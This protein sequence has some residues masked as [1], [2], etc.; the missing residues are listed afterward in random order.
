MKN[1][2]IYFSL[3]LIPTWFFFRFT[4]TPLW[5]PRCLVEKKWVK[6]SAYMLNLDHSLFGPMYLL[7]CA[8]GLW[9]WVFVWYPSVLSYCAI[10]E[11]VCL[12]FCRVADWPLRITTIVIVYVLLLLNINV[13]LLLVSTAYLSNN[14]LFLDVFL[15]VS[16]KTVGWRILRLSH[17]VGVG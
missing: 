4:Y 1:F 14:S 12:L 11:P 5:Y 17:I 2:K 3:Y 8:M 7:L 10:I 9:A 16:L 6:I 13:E 15:G